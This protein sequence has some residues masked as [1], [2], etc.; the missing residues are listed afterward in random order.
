MSDFVTIAKASEI[1][2]GSMQFV[3]I[4]GLRIVLVNA[5]G[6]FYALDGKCTHQHLTMMGGFI[7]A[8]SIVCPYHGGQFSL[9]TGQVEFSPPMEPLKTYE[10]KVEDDMLKLKYPD[11]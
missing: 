5:K 2:P 8:E 7:D 1:E 9:K 3:D 6:N 4:N 10:I 11:S